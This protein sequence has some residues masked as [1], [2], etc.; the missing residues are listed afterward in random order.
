MCM[1]LRCCYNVEV[2]AQRRTCTYFKHT[3]YLHVPGQ[4]GAA[5]SGIS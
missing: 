5:L 1:L 4:I 3:C 2:P